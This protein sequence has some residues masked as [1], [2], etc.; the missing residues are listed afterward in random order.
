MDNSFTSIAKA[1]MWGHCVNDAI[2]KLLQFQISTNITNVIITFV[3]AITSNKESVLTAVQLLWVNI[4]TDTLAVL[5]SESPLDRTPDTSLALG[6]MSIPPGVLIRCISTPPLECPF[7][8]LRIMSPD[9][10]L[11]TTKPDTTERNEAISMV[12]DDSSLFSSL[13]GGRGGRINV[14]PLIVKSRKLRISKGDWVA[15]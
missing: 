15:M 1:I 2:R 13:R 5:T 12:W 8:K 4:I 6:F 9:A 11:P 14:S 10:V 3:S 7:I